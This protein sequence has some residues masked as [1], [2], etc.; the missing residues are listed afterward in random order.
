MRSRLVRP[1]AK[2]TMN[3]AKVLAGSTIASTSREAPLQVGDLLLRKV[4]AKEK[5]L[6]AAGAEPTPL[7][8][9]R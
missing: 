5:H 1:W 2:W 8:S 3:T 4:I 9:S 6:L 7:T